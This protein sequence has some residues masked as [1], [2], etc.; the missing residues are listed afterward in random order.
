MIP[1]LV[2]L[3]PSKSLV[4]FGKCAENDELIAVPVGAD[5]MSPR[6]FGSMSPIR[7]INQPIE[8]TCSLDADVINL[9]TI[10]LKQANRVL[11]GPLFA[12]WLQL[13]AAFFFL[14]FSPHTGARTWS[15]SLCL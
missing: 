9:L 3:E 1:H 7:L 2:K 11:S 12:R 15:R 10:T 8:S 14:F 5:R 4:G 13:K 6:P